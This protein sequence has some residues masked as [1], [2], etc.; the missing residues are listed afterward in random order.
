[1][2]LLT[3]SVLIGYHENEHKVY[4]HDRGDEN[5]IFKCSTFLSCCSR[6]G[7]H[8]EYRQMIKE[9]PKKS[10]V[11]FVEYITMM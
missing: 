3:G 6:D 5:K 9:F 1:M 10:H 2:I 4:E 7:L 11:S 8:Y